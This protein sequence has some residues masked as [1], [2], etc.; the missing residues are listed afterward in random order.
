[1]PEMGS[2]RLLVAGISWPPETF[3]DRLIRGLID[4]GVEVT[5]ACPTRPGGVSPGNGKL[6]WLATP[7][8]SGSFPRRLARLGGLAARAAARAPHH[9]RLFSR[10]AREATSWVERFQCWHRLLPFAEGCWEAL[11]FPWNTAAITYLPLFD[12]GCPV[13]VSCRGSQ[14]HVAP[15]NP[16]RLAIRDGLRRSFERAA[17]VHCVSD[18]I[19]QQ[20]IG[21][22]LDPAK[23]WVIRPAVDPAQFSPCEQPRTANATLRIIST[24]SLISL[25]GHEYALL[26]IRRLLDQGLRV[27]LEIIGSGADR[28]RLVFAIHDLELEPHVR[29]HGRLTPEEV[30]QKLQQADLFLLSSVSEG[31]SNAVLEAMACGLPIVTTDSGGM[32][33]AVTDGVEG[34]LVPA[35]DPAAMSGAL[36]RF[37]ADPT[38]RARMGRAGRARVLRE[39]S[40]HAQ[41]DQWL[42]LYRSILDDKQ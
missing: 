5:V 11:Y 28:Q 20:A 3:I 29:L 41:I 35:R 13:V 26:A 8:W 12:L 27:Q 33:E 2:F 25:K 24:G 19:K 18:E 22:G 23:A 39:F 6:H 31:I 21:F 1:M 38:L 4:A 15:H 10:H 34:F 16:R 14:I 7:A 9:V 30:R 17:A 37:A 32:R 36:A 40:L 42:A